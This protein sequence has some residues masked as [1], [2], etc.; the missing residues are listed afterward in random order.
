M[1]LSIFRKDPR[2][3]ARSIFKKVATPLNR[4]FG[5]VASGID[6]VSPQIQSVLN[7]PA[8]QRIADMV[9]GG[10]ALDLARRGA[11]LLPTAS[12]IARKGEY[13]TDVGTFDKATSSV[14]ELE[15]A[16]NR[17]KN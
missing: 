9:G 4:I 5:K 1:V 2:K 7:N 14:N 17:L 10:K 3:S 12:R 16:V 8:T 13:A 15:K 11:D 6:K